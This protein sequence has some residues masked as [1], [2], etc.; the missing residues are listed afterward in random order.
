MSLVVVNVTRNRITLLILRITNMDVERACK[1]PLVRGY[2]QRQVHECV[3]NLHPAAVHQVEAVA[4]L[5]AE[6]E[7]AHSFAVRVLGIRV[8]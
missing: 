2:Q 8:Q 5:C 6:E 7:E 3:L 1:R 4:N